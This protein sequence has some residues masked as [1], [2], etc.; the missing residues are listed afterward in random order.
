MKNFYLIFFLFLFL[1]LN[2]CIYPSHEKEK[3]TKEIKV[4]EKRIFLQKEKMKKDSIRRDSLVEELS[5]YYGVNDSIA[6]GDTF[7]WGDE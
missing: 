1:F 2:S 3:D 6:V 4:I 5:K 7:M